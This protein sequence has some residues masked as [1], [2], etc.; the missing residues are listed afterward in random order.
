MQLHFLVFIMPD[1]F[2]RFRLRYIFCTTLSVTIPS[3]VGGDN[4]STKE[5]TMIVLSTSL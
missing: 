1:F 2:K 5:I 3:V 4:D